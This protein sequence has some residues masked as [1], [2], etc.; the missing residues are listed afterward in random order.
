MIC[1][2]VCI[3]AIRSEVTGNLEANI[4]E[5]TGVHQKGKLCP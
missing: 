3:A 2:F 4:G 5:V 1:L